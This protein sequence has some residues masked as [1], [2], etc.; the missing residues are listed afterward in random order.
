LRERDFGPVSKRYPP[1]P[2][3]KPPLQPLVEDVVLGFGFR[4]LSERKAAEPAVARG[5]D[6]LARQGDRP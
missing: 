5:Y 3:I 2:E 6:Q 1:G 4:H